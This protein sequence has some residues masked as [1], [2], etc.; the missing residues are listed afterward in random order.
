MDRK[1]TMLFLYAFCAVLIVLGAAVPDF[2]LLV[3]IG[4]TGAYGVSRL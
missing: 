3:P 2:D 4:L 1:T